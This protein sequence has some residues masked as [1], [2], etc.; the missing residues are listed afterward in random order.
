MSTLERPC[1]PLLSK[2]E[3]TKKSEKMSSSLQ[4]KLQFQA[5]WLY[6]MRDMKQSEIAELL[7]TSRASVALYLKQARERGMLSISMA[8]DIFREHVVAQQLEQEFGLEAAYV[9]APHGV[10]N[11]TDPLQDCAIL[12]GEVLLKF[13]EENDELGVAWGLTLYE[14]AK[15]LP[16]KTVRG[17]EV[18]QLCGNLGAPFGYAPERCTLEI[19]NRLSAKSRNLY[20]PLTVSTVELAQQLSKEPIIAEQL[21]ILES[22]TKTI[23]SFG[24]CNV[25]SHIVSCGSLT[26]K[27]M[28]QAY[29][30]GARAVVAGRLINQQGQP[31]QEAHKSRII[32][33]TLDRIKKIPFRIAVSAGI[34]KAEAILAGLTGDFATH[35]VVDLET[36]EAVLKLKQIERD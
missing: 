6:Y 32:G 35:L 25:N 36:A 13:I 1:L 30:R 20:A 21:A 28:R 2:G 10:K 26:A 14:L 34:E 17:L 15:R 24:S 8:T 5:A 11:H 33:I 9:L 18:V 19:A 7:Q 31:F 4:S 27:E 12:G 3:Q 23:F 29:K 16:L 22:C